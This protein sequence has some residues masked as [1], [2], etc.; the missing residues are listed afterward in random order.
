MKKVALIYS[1]NLS[2]P[3]GAS[4]IIRNFAD[5]KAIFTKNGIQLS[6]YAPDMQNQEV[7]ISVQKEGEKGFYSKSA[8]IISNY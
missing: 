1:A 6:I 8:E 3:T 7:K 2:N 4:A 5:S